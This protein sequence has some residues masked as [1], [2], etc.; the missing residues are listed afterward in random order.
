MGFTRE[1]AYTCLAAVCSCLFWP[2]T[3]QPLSGSTITS[4]S[5]AVSCAASLMAQQGCCPSACCSPPDPGMLAGLTLHTQGA[6]GSQAFPKRCRMQPASH[7]PPTSQH[8]LPQLP[9]PQQPGSR[10]N[11]STSS[12][13][14]SS[15]GCSICASRDTGV[16]LNG[17]CQARPRH[18]TCQGAAASVQQAQHGWACYTGAIRA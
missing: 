8:Q 12:G 1:A 11:S 4:R 2:T 6:Q 17:C 16:L 10:L 7:C 13:Y 15:Q 14:L 9:G 3:L 5:K 18:C